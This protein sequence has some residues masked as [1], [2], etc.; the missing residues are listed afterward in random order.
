MK[1]DRLV[2]VGGCGTGWSNEESVKLRE[3]MDT[4]KEDKPSVALRRKGAVFVRPLL[5]AEVEYRAWT[6]DDKLR[7][8]SFKGLRERADDATVFSLDREQLSG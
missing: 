7:H 3:L 6:E 1:K 4:I 2:Y 8:P 5:V